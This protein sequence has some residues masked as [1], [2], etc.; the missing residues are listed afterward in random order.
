M[1]SR[2]SGAIAKWLGQSGIDD[3][4]ACDVAPYLSNFQFTKGYT[5]KER[6]RISVTISQ[7]QEGLITVSIDA[8]MP[9]LRI[10]APS[11][12]VLVKMVVP[13]AGAC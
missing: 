10:A 8:F 1:Q 5:F 11:G 9:A 6:F 13:V 3:L 4:P 7:P 2:F 12:T